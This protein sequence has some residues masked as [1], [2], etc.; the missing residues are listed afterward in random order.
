MNILAD[1]L[2]RPVFPGKQVARLRAQL[3]TSLAIR[4]QSTRDMASLNFDQIVYKD[5][6]YSRPEDGFP[7]TVQSITRD[8]LADF[9]HKY[10]GPRG[11]V[12]AIVGAVDPQEAVEKVRLA[13][14]DW[15]NPEQPQPLDLPPLSPLGDSVPQHAAIPGK[16]QSDIVMGVAGPP[17]RAANFLPAL[18]G[19]S[20]LGQFGMMGRIGEVVREKSGMAYYAY[21]SLSGGLGPGPWTVSAGVD[22]KNVARAIELIRAEIGRFVSEP[23]SEQELSDSKA[24]F[25][26]RLPLAMES[27]AGV[28]SALLNLERFGLP[29]DYY[30]RYAEMI[31]AITAEQVLEAAQAYLHAEKLGIGTAG[32]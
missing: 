13:L 11:M 5:H 10:Y 19:N 14:G 28:T 25:I 7:E 20:V 12:V 15:E 26:G 23:V 21:S 24:N 8:D 1:T 30:R 27:N 16:S 6:P 3:L 2:R 31:N 18:L 9:H 29:P 22:P 17:R 32:P 4:S